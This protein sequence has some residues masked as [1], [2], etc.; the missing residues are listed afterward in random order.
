MLV[1]EED[2]EEEFEEEFEEELEEELSQEQL[3]TVPDFPEDDPDEI[4]SHATSFSDMYVIDEK[5]ESR[6]KQIAFEKYMA[7]KAI[8]AKAIQRKQK[9]KEKLERKA[10]R[11]QERKANAHKKIK[12]GK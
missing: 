2:E 12:T 6:L 11:L 1:N 4:N 5:E 10:K 9:E 8:E 3:N 7:E